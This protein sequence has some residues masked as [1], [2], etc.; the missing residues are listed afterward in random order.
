MDHIATAHFTDGKTK[1][2][3]GG[4][5]C[6]SLRVTEGTALGFQEDPSS[7]LSSLLHKSPSTPRRCVW[8]ENGRCL[9][10]PFPSSSAG[11]PRLTEN[12]IA[13]MITLIINGR[14][15]SGWRGK[16]EVWELARISQALLPSQADTTP[17]SSKGRFLPGGRIHSSS[18][19]FN[20]FLLP[21][22]PSTFLP[23]LGHSPMPNTMG[24]WLFRYS[25]I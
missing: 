16:A 3:A 7:G 8:F 13:I 9:Q 1:A 18:I 17:T 23:L 14:E 12:S 25:L 15:T 19:F 5:G 22:L 10:M 4:V 6:D 11:F 21:C 2:Q 24:L 20:P